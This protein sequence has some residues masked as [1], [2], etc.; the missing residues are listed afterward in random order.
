M[1]TLKRL[2]V[3]T[4]FSPLAEIAVRRA[5]DLAGRDGAR[6]DV[7]HAFPTSAFFDTAFAGGIWPARIQTDAEHR[8]TQIRDAAQAQGVRC[9]THLM[10][11]AAH[12]MVGEIVERAQPDLIVI[13]AHA[14]G[15]VRQFFLGGTAARILA[16]APCPVLVA[17]SDG[18]AAYRCAVV[19]VDLG[20]RSAAVL[21]AAAQVAS[22]ADLVPAHAFLAPLEGRMRQ[23]GCS[24]AELA[25]HI[26]QAAT[27][28]RSAMGAWLHSTGREA[29]AARS[30]IVHG[31]P[32]PALPDLVR[33]LDAD[34]IAV[35]RHSGSRMG[36]VLL[37]SVPRFL[38]YY[39]PCDVLVA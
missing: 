11:G 33:E 31:D 29:L 25:A 7:V 32:N 26:D 6:L 37:G 22:G 8:L 27:E 19:A 21:D 13:G 20:Q 1:S 39:A 2:V 34:L 24:D 9:T 38:A 17:R 30:R 5:I 23:H 10:H 3:A 28:A 12:R 4:D 18:S 15:A 35:G 36:E 16:A 14:R